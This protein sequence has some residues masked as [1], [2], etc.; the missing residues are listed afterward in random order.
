MTYLATLVGRALFYQFI[1]VS[2]IYIFAFHIGPSV[3]PENLGHQNIG[4]LTTAP[5]C[6]ET[7]NTTK[8]SGEEGPNEYGLGVVVKKWTKTRDRQLLQHNAT[9]LSL[10][11]AYTLAG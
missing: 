2:Y 9:G 4:D 3:L 10:S 6:C 7:E 11:E 8:T 1:V 5:I